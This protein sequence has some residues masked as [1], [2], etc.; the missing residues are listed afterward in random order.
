M[1]N[2]GCKAAIY[3]VCCILLLLDLGYFLLLVSERYA[4]DFVIND[5]NDTWQQLHMQSDK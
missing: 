1:K 3:A 4:R 5:L 2:A